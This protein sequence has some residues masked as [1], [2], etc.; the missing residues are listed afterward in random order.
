MLSRFQKEDESECLTQKQTEV[1][2][3]SDFTRLFLEFQVD[4][5]DE[6]KGMQRGFLGYLRS[7]GGSVLTFLVIHG[8]A[9]GI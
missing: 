9:P 8:H 1:K 2:N 5:S 6:E 3:L 4:M 7:R